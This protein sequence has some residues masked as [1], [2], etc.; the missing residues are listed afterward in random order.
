[1]PRTVAYDAVSLPKYNWN[2]GSC[3]PCATM[4]SLANSATSYVSLNV[5]V[6]QVQSTRVGNTH[7]SACSSIRRW[8]E[9]QLLWIVTLGL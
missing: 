7:A 5:S 3:G 8:V 4:Y 2:T 9:L 6:H 1:M